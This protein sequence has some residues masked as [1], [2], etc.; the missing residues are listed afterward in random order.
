MEFDGTLECKQCSKFRAVTI[1]NPKSCEHCGAYYSADQIAFLNKVLKRPEVHFPAPEKTL[2]SPFTAKDALC[3]ISEVLSQQ[4]L[5]NLWSPIHFSV[6]GFTQGQFFEITA[7]KKYY[8]T[9]KGFGQI[10]DTEAGSKVE[11]SFKAKNPFLDWLWFPIR[12]PVKK[13]ILDFFEENI[14]ATLPNQ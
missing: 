13:R 8:G 10:V 2:F 9:V 1:D 11:I 14:Q 6:Y 7:A 5:I 4:N 12:R 3:K